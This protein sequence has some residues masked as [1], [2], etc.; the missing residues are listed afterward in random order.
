[1]TL[2]N[3]QIHAFR[4]A[5]YRFYRKEGRHEL[6]WR[7]TDDP[8]R[9]LLSEIMLQQTQV[10]RVAVRYEEFLALFPSLEALADASLR[11]VLAAWS[12][13]GY[14]RRARFLHELAGV[15]IRDHGGRLPRTVDALRELPGI[16]E[17]TASAVAC[18][19][20]R[21]PVPMIETNIRRAII[22][23][24][25]SKNAGYSGLESDMPL[26]AAEEAR[27]GTVE[28][29]SSAVEDR[30]SDAGENAA[31]VFPERREEFRPRTV[32]A[33]VHD[34]EVRGVAV[35]LLD[36]GYPRE[37]NYALM[38]YGQ[39]L[40]RHVPN[41][42]R[43]SAHYTRQSRFEGSRRQVRGALLKVLAGVADADEQTL[44][45]ETGFMHERVHSVLSDLAREGFVEVVEGGFRESNRDRR[46]RVR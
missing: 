45:D 29:R 8:Y 22:Y 43:H 4:A 11:D 7:L 15:V 28:S 24:F 2:S 18:F 25:F 12:G 13:L 26:F 46:W 30:A 17:Y 1:M 9:I 33:A 37:W 40:S 3:E 19:A 23:S 36:R 16:G 39:A 44:V 21:A 27:G 34:R 38:D 42:N 31:V 5:V 32:P 14:N 35:Q 6:A 20:Y 41:P 10:S